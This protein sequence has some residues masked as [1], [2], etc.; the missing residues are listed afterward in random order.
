[1]PEPRLKCNAAF[2]AK[3]WIGLQGERAHTLTIE[4]AS[5][6]AGRQQS[7]ISLAGQSALLGLVFSLLEI[8]PL[9]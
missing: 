2:D 5:K 8:A 6:L 1:M 4:K 7:P 9:L 3:G